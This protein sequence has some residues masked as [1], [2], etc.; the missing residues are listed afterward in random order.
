MRKQINRQPYLWLGMSVSAWLGLLIRNRFAIHWRRLHIVL[1]VS[2]SCLH[3]SILGGFEL[4]VFGIRIA[5]TRVHPAPVFILGHWRSGTTLLHELFA[6]D[7]RFACPSTYECLSPN[8]FLLT[9]RWMPA[10]LAWTLPTRRPMDNMAVGFTRPQEDEFALCLLGQPSPLEHVAFPNRNGPEDPQFDVASQSPIR[11]HRWQRSYMRFLKRITIAHN[12]NPIVLK[13]P[14]HM[15]RIRLLLKLFPDAR[16]VHI[17]R[18]PYELYPSTLHLWRSM[19]AHHSLQ[20]PAWDK[21]QERILNMYA[22]MHERFEQERSLIP[23]GHLHQ[24]RYEELVA[25]PLAVMEETYRQL[26]LGDFSSTRQTMENYLDSV[27][28]HQSN[29]LTVTD[30]ERTLI[31]RRWRHFIEQQGYEIRE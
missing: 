22:S 15:M 18:D 6:C 2:A 20:K 12:G 11:Q 26:Q 25:A 29:Q 28:D 3:H 31:T 17:T 7:Q 14:P 27:K 8:H 19:Y 30:N 16:F 9:R 24:V 1:I 4:L 23:A 21:L 5:R 13:S 10:L